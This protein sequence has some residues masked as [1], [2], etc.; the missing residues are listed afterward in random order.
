MNRRP[1]P[2]RP[3]AWLAA[4][5]ALAWLMIAG[6]SQSVQVQSDFPDPLVQALPYSVGLRYLP[7]FV[8]YT[9]SEDLP[10]DVTWNFAIGT[11]NRKLFDKVF[12][13][14]FEQTVVL[15]PD[16]SGA[17]LDLVVEPAVDALEFSLPRQSRSEQYAV[18]IRYNLHV[19]GPDGQLVTDWPVSAYGQSDSRLMKGD[20]S[21]R[22]ATIKAMRDAATIMIQGFAADEKI[23]QALGTDDS[24]AT[25]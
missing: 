18:W 2:H 20:I 17:G 4:A 9:Y 3:P 14:L 23:R 5:G 24:D 7:E 22:Q 13:S 15:E 19:F 21:M 16:A 1:H 6:C 25:P 8:E 12:A 11:S 10:N